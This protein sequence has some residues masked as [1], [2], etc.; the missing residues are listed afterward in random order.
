[1]ASSLIRR[2]TAA[3]AVRL[4]ARGLGRGTNARNARLGLRGRIGRGVGL[5]IRFALKE[6]RF[7]PD[8]RHHLNRFGG[9]ERSKT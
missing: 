7:Q 1:M 4:C 3:P 9:P 2:A 6:R 5:R 8:H